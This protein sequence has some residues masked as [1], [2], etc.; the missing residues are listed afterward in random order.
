MNLLECIKMFNAFGSIQ[1]SFRVFYDGLYL[2]SG[3]LFQVY[4]FPQFCIHDPTEYEVLGTISEF[5]YD[6]IS[7]LRFEVHGISV[8]SIVE[9]FDEL[10]PELDISTIGMA[11]R[12]LLEKPKKI[13]IVFDVALSELDPKQ[14]CNYTGLNG[15]QKINYAI[16]KYRNKM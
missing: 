12:F 14:F 16:F 3:D 2:C 1:Y 7:L 5:L 9:T 8:H 15:F 10:S 6:F 4:M 13:N 11:S